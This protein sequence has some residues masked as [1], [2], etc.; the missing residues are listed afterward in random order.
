[1]CSWT[2]DSFYSVLPRMKNVNNPIINVFSNFS[3]FSL[4]HKQRDG[5]IRRIF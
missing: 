2:D 5:V 3:L 1:M 4:Y